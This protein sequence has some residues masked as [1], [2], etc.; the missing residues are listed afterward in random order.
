MKK[1]KAKGS[2]AIRNSE[3]AK[4]AAD[5]QPIIDPALLYDMSGFV[6]DPEEWFRTPNMVFEGRA[7]IELL[8]TPDEAVLRNRINMA[9]Y[10]L[11]S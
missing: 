3:A 1:V 4:P 8:G 5:P 6:D 7:P 11:Y 2:K 9:K 10:G